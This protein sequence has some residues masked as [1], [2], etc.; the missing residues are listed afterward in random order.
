MLSDSCV[1]ITDNTC[2]ISPRYGS[3]ERKFRQ[4][5]WPSTYK[6][7]VWPSVREVYIYLYYK[8]AVSSKLFV[9]HSEQRP[10]E[11][12]GLGGLAAACAASS[13]TD[14]QWR[15][16]PSRCAAWWLVILHFSFYWI[17]PVWC[18]VF[19]ADRLRSESSVDS[20]HRCYQQRRRRLDLILVF[21]HHLRQ[22]R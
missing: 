18:R 5:N 14:V 7:L 8:I 1:N 3:L 22:Q 12:G 9:D 2:I 20:L 15:Y 19:K 13:R 11:W 10:P 17:V 4:R 6:A 16:K 21:H